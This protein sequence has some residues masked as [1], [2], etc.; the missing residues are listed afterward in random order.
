IEFI[1]GE[2]GIR[3]ASHE[4]VN[5]LVELKN[6]FGFTLVADEVQSGIGRSGKP[7]AFNHFE[8]EPD[9]IIV[10]KAIGGGLPLGAL[11]TNKKY[12]EVFQA[13][14]HGSTFGGNPVAC[15]AGLVIISEVFENGLINNVKTLGNYFIS[16]L[17]QFKE[18][19]PKIINDVRGFGFMIGVELNTNCRDIV[20]SFRDNNILVNC[21]SENVIRIL[22]PLISTEDNIDYFLKIFS[23]KLFK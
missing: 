11:I 3:I 20:K 15:S 19:Y 4:F 5:K 18:K 9:L 13:G 21:T 14:D 1:Q 23:G 7:F 6:K 10:A 8:V 2:G 22:P 17:N 12:S 16:E